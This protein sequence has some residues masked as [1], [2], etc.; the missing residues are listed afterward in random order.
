MPRWFAKRINGWVRDK[1][2]DYQKEL[3]KY[4]IDNNIDLKN[5][6]SLGEKD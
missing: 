4:C 1:E 5:H 2:C 3:E 6:Q